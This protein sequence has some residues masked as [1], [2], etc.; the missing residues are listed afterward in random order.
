MYQGSPS[1][2]QALFRDFCDWVHWHR[3]KQRS[4]SNVKARPLRS[5]HVARQRAVLQASGWNQS[6]GPATS[7]DTEAVQ[8]PFVRSAWGLSPSWGH[9]QNHQASLS[10]QLFVFG[11]SFKNP[12]SNIVRRHRF[13][14]S[15]EVENETMAED[16]QGHSSNVI[17]T[18]ID[19]PV[20]NRPG[21]GS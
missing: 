1:K 6:I 8:R 17:T 11:Q 13:A 5:A 15:S 2:D 7:P 10:R 12:A 9:P 20:K 16:G 4:R 14:L 21:F 19:L 3:K 18:H